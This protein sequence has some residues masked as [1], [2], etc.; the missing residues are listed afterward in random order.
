MSNTG[1]EIKWT[2]WE[3]SKGTDSHYSAFSC[4]SAASTA[5]CADD[6]KLLCFDPSHSANST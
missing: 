2:R 6:D 5:F 4:K 3:M 1:R